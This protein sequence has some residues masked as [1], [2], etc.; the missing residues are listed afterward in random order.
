MDVE[1]IQ[2]SLQ[3]KLDEFRKH[4][5]IREIDSAKMGLLFGQSLWDQVPTSSGTAHD[6]TWKK[7]EKTGGETGL[8]NESCYSGEKSKR[9]RTFQLLVM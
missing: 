8:Q 5:G 9:R 4:I 1:Q 2:V 6:A 3:G 7:H